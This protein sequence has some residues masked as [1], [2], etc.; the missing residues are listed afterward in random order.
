LQDVAMLGGDGGLIAVDVLGNAA[1][2]F[3]SEG[4]KRGLATSAGQF[5]V[6]VGR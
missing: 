4:M 6:A 2:P 5:H 3:L 1:L